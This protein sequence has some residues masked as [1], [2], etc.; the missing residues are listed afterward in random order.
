[1]DAKVIEVKRKPPLWSV[2]ASA[3]Y[4]AWFSGTNARA[5]AIAY[6]TANFGEFTIVEKPVPK[7]DQARIDKIA[8][9]SEPI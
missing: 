9:L 4:V 8:G 6:A 7:R 2:K 3:R 5:L 1:M